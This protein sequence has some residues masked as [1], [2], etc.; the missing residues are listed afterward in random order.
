VEYPQQVSHL[1]Q[2]VNPTKNKL[3][4]IDVGNKKPMISVIPKFNKIIGRVP[5]TNTTTPSIP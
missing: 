4:L 5:T 2:Y 3:I 1:P